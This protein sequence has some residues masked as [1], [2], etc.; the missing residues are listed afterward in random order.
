[1]TQKQRKSVALEVI[2][3]T[4]RRGFMK[5]AAAAGAGLIGFPGSVARNPLEAMSMYRSSEG[6]AVG[7]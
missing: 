6:E 3:P 1:M 7:R 4:D 2:S 5:G